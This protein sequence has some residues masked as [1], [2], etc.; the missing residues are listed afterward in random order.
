MSKY[1]LAQLN[2]AKPAYPL[3]SPELR[4]FVD[5]LDLINSLAERSDGFIWRLQTEAG[6]ATEIDAFGP[7]FIV[8]MSTWRDVDSLQKFV[9]KTIH[10]QF[11]KRRHE[12]FSKIDSHMVLWWIP[13]G[14]EPTV[15]EARCKLDKISRSGSSIDAFD[16]SNIFNPPSCTVPPK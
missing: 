14:I 15:E 7:D 8:N 3:D 11:I 13:D 10:A 6:N 16:F 1:I 2:I 12:W 9:Y 4:E 5:N